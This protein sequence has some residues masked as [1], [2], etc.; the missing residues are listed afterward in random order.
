MSTDHAPQRAPSD[1]KQDALQGPT[2]PDVTLFD[3]KKERWV[4]WKVDLLLMPILTLSYGL[5]FVSASSLSR[6]EV[7]DASVTLVRQICVQQCCRLRDARRSWS[8]DPG[9]WLSSTTI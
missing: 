8:A 3:R 9:S 2:E 5:Q 7:I 1:L 6:C 4:L